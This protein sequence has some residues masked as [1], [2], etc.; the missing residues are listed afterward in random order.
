MIFCDL[1]NPQLS[2]TLQRSRGRELLLR[3][4]IRVYTKPQDLL[5]KTLLCE[6]II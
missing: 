2:R 4:K 1:S 6:T 3:M 5:R